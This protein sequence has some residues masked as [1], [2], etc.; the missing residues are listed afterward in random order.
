MY[1]DKDDKVEE[2]TDLRAFD[3]PKDED[4]QTW[5]S[6]GGK[7]SEDLGQVTAK[8][9]PKPKKKTPKKVKV[10]LN[11]FIGNNYSD[12]HLGRLRRGEVVEVSK[13]KADE[14]LAVQDHNGR[15]RFSKL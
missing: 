10:Q 2:S 9:K 3:D 15:N 5:E 4:V 14:L 6:E 7:T 11:K 1:N 12:S 8:T 13:E